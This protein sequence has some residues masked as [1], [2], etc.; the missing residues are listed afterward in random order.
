MLI[1][2]ITDTHV[3]APGT[4][5]YRDQIDTNT[6]FARAIER[7]NALVPRPDCVIVTGDLTDHG[8]LPEY[9]EFTRLLAG[10]EIPHY[11]VIG[12][13]DDRTMMM[14]ALDMPYLQQDGDGFVQ[15]VVDHL[16][17]RLIM[18]DSCSDDHHVG[19]YCER[20]LA[21]LRARLAEAPERPTVV[22]LHHPPFDTGIV[23]MDAGGADWAAGLVDAIAA[24]PNVQRILCG[25]VH[26]SVQTRVGSSIASICP[27][28]AHQVT[29]DLGVVPM[30][31]NF[32]EMEPPG[33]Q[34]HLY[35]NGMM[36]T[37]TAPIERYPGVAPLAPDV[38]AK[39]K[40]LGGADA[41]SKKEL[42]F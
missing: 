32:F 24:Y 25:H 33:F 3:V 37:H 4:R 13:H 20:R 36:V 23:M 10:L 30:T 42:L 12:N 41:M 40:M 15:Y 21:W 16:P 31:D 2:H 39:L 27:S 8:T 5:A 14:A 1:A 26:R 34:L 35:R 17:V 19:Q 22:A 18:L 28:T 6:M 11:L 29:L 9:R 38:L 7:L